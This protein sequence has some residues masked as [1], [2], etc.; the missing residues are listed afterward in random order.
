MP[1]LQ[2]VHETLKDIQEQKGMKAQ[3]PKN[4]NVGFRMSAYDRT[5]AMGEESF[6]LNLFYFDPFFIF[7]IK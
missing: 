6:I 3:A 5:P 1:V 4:A 7:V 2:I